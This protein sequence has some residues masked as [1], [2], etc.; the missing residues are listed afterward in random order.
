MQ[1][2][3]ALWDRGVRVMVSIVLLILG[4][5]AWNGWQGTWYGILGLIIGVV[6]MLTAAL[7]WCP[8]Y[9]VCKFSTKK[10]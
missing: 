4:G 1:K 3:L 2:N 10:S 7:G 9:G 8:C 6:L 5:W